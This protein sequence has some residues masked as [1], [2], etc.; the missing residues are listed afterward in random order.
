MV[1]DLSSG[2]TPGTL[3]STGL[4]AVLELASNGA[5]VPHAASTGGLSSLSLL[6]PVVCSVVTLASLPH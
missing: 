4:E 1:H 2:S 5:E 3:G 6:G